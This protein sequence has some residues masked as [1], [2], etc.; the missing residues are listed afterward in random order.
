MSLTQALATALSGLRASQAG[1]SI[2]SANV[3]NAQTPGY[4]RKNA[5][6]EATAAGNDGSGVRIAAINRQLDEYVQRQLRVE[7][8]GA[9]YADTRAQLYSQ[10]QNIYGV[11]G[12]DSSLETAYNSFTS[13]LQALSTSPDS[14]S[15]RNGVLGTAQALT[16]QLNGMSTA[17][18]ALRSQAELGIAD[19]VTKAND[20]MQR[21]ADINQQLGTASANDATTAG[22]LDQRDQAIDQL[23]QLMDINVVQSDHNQITIFN[24]SGIQLV[25]TQPSKLVFDAQGT[26]TPSSVWSA[27][28]NKRMVGTILLT[29]ANGST[30]DLV[31]SKAVR[32]GQIAAYLEMRD[33]AL[34]EAQSQ[35]D[36]LAAGMA[37]ALSDR[38]TAGTPVAGVPPGFDIDLGSLLPGNTVRVTYTDSVTNAQHVITLMRV[39]DPAALPLPDSATSDP[40]D[41]VI[42][43]S[44]AAGMGSVVNQISVALGGT[45]PQFSNPVGTTLRVL[46]SAGSGAHVDAVASTVTVT[47][48]TGGSPELP[49]FM[50]GSNP[51]SG[52]MSVSGTQGVGFAARIGVNANL[53][54]DP[55]RLVVYQLTPLTAAG[56]PTRPNFIYDQL[57][58]GSQT[59]SPRAGIGTTGAPFVGTLP[60]F[61]RQLLSQQGDAAQAADNL[62]QGQDVVLKSLQK[63]FDDSASVN[64]DEEMANLLSLQNS[65]AAN[66]RVLSAVNSMFDTLMKM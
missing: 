34:P 9:S 57:T 3:A 12:S 19:A 40:K 53:L 11:P 24:S 56:D 27:D 8:S 26:M 39:E 21:I 23:A 20:A 59:F 60:T 25:G 2:V 54:A 17:V 4:V 15:A 41:K 13:A 37:R 35:L 10:L 61:L 49:F 29:S 32:S 42:G 16:H 64:I 65:Y 38:S 5:V 46:D 7:S 52:V 22:L 6:M 44:F 43:I 58:T 66:A 31:A 18:Q 33:Q 30:L 62:K 14:A 36:E 50:D 51:F 28:P 63:R 1:I 55:S 45:V 48:L 47:S